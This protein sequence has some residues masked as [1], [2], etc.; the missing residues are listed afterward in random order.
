M[1]FR[2]LMSS[3]RG[4]AYIA[5]CGAD[6]LL[7]EAGGSLR[8]LRG[9]CDYRI[10]TDALVT[11]EHGDHAQGVD[12]LLKGGVDVWA[13]AGTLGAL[14]VRDHYRSHVVTPY[15]TTSIWTWA[16]MPVPTIHDAAEP[17]GFAIW[18]RHGES[19]FFATDTS[20][21]AHAVSGFDIVAVECSYQ[22]DLLWNVEPFLRRRILSTHQGLDHLLFWLQ[23]CDLSKTREIHLLHISRD[24]AVAAEC[25]EAVQAETGIPVFT[26]ENFYK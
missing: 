24:H 5:E 7:I 21:L 25:V 26:V 16:V 8:T 18:D 20:I 15:K 22:R 13:T 9:L 3:S 1:I 11:H 12:D 23:G 4:N 2:Q 10:P 6:R 19:L 17:V 14:G